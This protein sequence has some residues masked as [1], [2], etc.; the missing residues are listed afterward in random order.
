MNHLNQSTHH[1]LAGREVGNHAVTERTDGFYVLV[2]F[3]IHH[4]RLVTYSNHLF[5]TAIQCNNRGFVDHNL[6]IADNNGVGRT[7]VHCNLL[8]KTKKSHSFYP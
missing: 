2:C 5:G 6:I 3:L 4:F 1:L 8:H 7:K